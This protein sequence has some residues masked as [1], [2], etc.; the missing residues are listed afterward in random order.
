MI[1]VYIDYNTTSELIAT[2]YDE[3]IYMSC[4]P[5]LEK[6]A[7]EN[8]GVLI[9]SIDSESEEMKSVFY[10]NKYKVAYKNVSKEA[11]ALQLQEEI[12]DNYDDYKINDINITRSSNK[13]NVKIQH[14]YDASS[15]IENLVLQQI[16][17]Y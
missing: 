2:F 3:S 10:C 13:I 17:L 7:K 5:A 12:G 1:K 8:N 15:K 16:P 9:E 4:L 6:V 11:I 14:F